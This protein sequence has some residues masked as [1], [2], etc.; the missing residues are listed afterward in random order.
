[1]AG[2]GVGSAAGATAAIFLYV[3]LLVA[4]EVC[5]VVQYNQLLAWLL[6]VRQKNEDLLP[7]WELPRGVWHLAQQILDGI[8]G[9]G[10]M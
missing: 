7:R 1:V 9:Y 3:L 5:S 10:H 6:I 2:V 4:V 8:E